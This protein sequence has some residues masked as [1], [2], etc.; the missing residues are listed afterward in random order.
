MY[1]CFAPNCKH[2]DKEWPRLDN[3]KQH[4]QRMHKFESTEE[5]IQRSNNWYEKERKQQQPTSTSTRGIPATDSQMLTS[6]LSHRQESPVRQQPQNYLSPEWRPASTAG[7]PR[8][9]SFSS[10]PNLSLHT[11]PSSAPSFRQPQSHVRFGVAHQSDQNSTGVMPTQW[12]SELFSENSYHMPRGRHTSAYTVPNPDT[13]ALSDLA[14]ISQ[15][16]YSGGL[17]TSQNDLAQIASNFSSEQQLNPPP[18]QDLQSP[19][20][21]P[22]EARRSSALLPSDMEAIRALIAESAGS[23]SNKNAAIFEILK[24]GIEKIKETRHRSA[25]ITT[26]ASSPSIITSTANSQPGSVDTRLTYGCPESGCTKS[27]PRPCDLKKHLKR[28]HRPYGCTFGK[29]YE[30]FGSKYDWKRHEN[31]QHFQQECWKCSLCSSSAGRK[32]KGPILSSS[33]QIFYRRNLFVTHMQKHSIS[34]DTIKEH[35]R[36]QRIGRNC[37]TRFWCGFCGKILALQKKGLEGADER[38]NH[39]DTHFKEGC[40][41]STWVDMDGSVE[42]GQQQGVNQGEEEE[43]PDDVLGADGIDCGKS[44]GGADDE[45]IAADESFEVGPGVDIGGNVHTAQAGQKRRRSS[46]LGRSSSST[47]SRPTQRR[48]TVLTEDGSPSTTLVHCHNCGN[49]PS[50]LKHNEQCATCSHMFCP[51]CSYTQPRGR[52]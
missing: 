6:G 27:Y 40:D 29:C 21:S 47:E 36:K 22:H 30:R 52:R 51:L 18:G 41:I 15:P 19:S 44:V 5:L 37:Q 1:K 49:G 25:T 24:A 48:R 11:S 17:T 33:A 9:S 12:A 42:K 26:A 23:R 16:S 39:I 50:V 28:H 4:L 13:S 2:C 46:D 38:F 45:D 8:H 7:R 20:I 10:Q 43:D 34:P 32:G 31:S 3:F 14:D 35:L